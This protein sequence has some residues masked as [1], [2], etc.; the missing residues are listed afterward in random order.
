MDSKLNER[1]N[2]RETS[3]DHRTIVKKSLTLIAGL[4]IVSV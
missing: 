3:S 1:K 2:L 4:T